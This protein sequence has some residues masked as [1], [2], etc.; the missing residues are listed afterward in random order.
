MDLESDHS[1][2]WD[3]NLD[4]G[5]DK[6]TE[7]YYPIDEDDEEKTWARRNTH[8]YNYGP[9]N[10]R[11]GTRF[12]NNGGYIGD[13]Y[14]YGGWPSPYPYG[15]NGPYLGQSSDKDVKRNPDGSIKEDQ[16]GDDKK[17]DGAKNN[18]A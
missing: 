1:A 6:A 15:Y 16:P 17:G 5:G 9:W 10:Y 2:D 12:F 7:G 18:A 11:W 3:K 4:K 14:M 8:Y 13:P